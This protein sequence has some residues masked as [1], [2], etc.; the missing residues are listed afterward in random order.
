M[1][2]T[3]IIEDDLSQTG[4]LL[5]LIKKNFKGVE[6]IATCTDVFDA[7]KK[8]NELNPQLIFLDIELGDYSG[9]DLLDMVENRNFE[10]IFTTYYNQYAIRAIKVAALDYI[11][12]PVSK[13][14]LKEALC[15]FN[16]KTSKVKVDNLISNLKVEEIDQK[17]ALAENNSVNFFKL[18]D[19]IY[20]HSENSSTEFYF[21][22]EK[23]KIVA[24]TGL[25]YYE[26]ILVPRGCF[27]RVHNRYLVNINYIKK[28]VKGESAYIVMNDFLKTTIPIA[29][30]RKEKFITFLKSQNVIF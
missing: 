22:S 8:I 11:E 5:G 2:K 7:V 28:F 29:R 20:C 24:T 23:R 15:R 18:K 3:I 27:F 25:F 21:S 26:E 14:Q 1:I 19:L 6:V 4:T 12:K 10:I 30:S 17:I 9:F 13:N 16:K